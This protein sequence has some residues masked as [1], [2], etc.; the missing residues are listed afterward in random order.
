MKT[1][2]IEPRETMRVLPGIVQP[3]LTWMTGVP[4]KGEKRWMRWTPLKAAFL[5]FGQIALGITIGAWTL[6]NFTPWHAPV[7][8]LAWLITAGGMRRAD[9]LLVHQSLHR[10]VT[11]SELGDRIV[12]ELITTLMWRMPYDVNRREHLLHHA[13]PCS[14]KDGDT[15]Y[16]LSTGMRPGMTQG[17]HFRYIIKT[18][19][20][21]KHHWGF[22][23]SR[24]RGNFTWKQRPYRLAMSV[25]FLALVIT[26]LVMSGLWMEWLLL[27]VLPVSFFFQCATFLYTQTEHRWWIYDN[28]Q[29]LT[30]AQRDELTFAR[31]CGEAVPDTSEMGFAAKI[32]AWGRWWF[33]VF[34]V[35]STYRMFVLVGD[36][37]Q[38]DIH[39]VRPTC[40]WP[41]SDHERAIDL[42]SS[43]DRYS[44]VWGSLFDHLYAAG[45]V[46]LTPQ[47]IAGGEVNRPTN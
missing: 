13:F 7:M 1:E 42:V 14:M 23:S 31:V 4:L 16:L 17:E 38:H 47:A 45:Q 10:M 40:D 36:T 24:I 37:V 27:W 44:V 19:L 12:G 18:L 8:L 20:S 28:A 5:A 41:N 39:H 6:H 35:H 46:Q 43:A 32:W 21:P 33:R 30:R 3:F 34:F 26:G 9:V 22:F 25:T 29:G 2:T 15:L 11:K